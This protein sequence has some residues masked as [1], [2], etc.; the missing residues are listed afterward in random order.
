M[1]LTDN[2][3]RIYRETR[4]K[5]KI[6]KNYTELF[7]TEKGVR[8]G[9]PLS[10]LLFTLFLAG[11]EEYL[12]RRQEGGITIKINRVHTLAYADDLAIIAETKDEMK[13]IIK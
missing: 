8:Q 6:G 7:W 11:I 12:K 9:C 13:R 4:S 10:P 3:K 1:N 5:V 2:A